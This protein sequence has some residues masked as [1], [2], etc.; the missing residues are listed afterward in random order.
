M[1]GFGFPAIVGGDFNELPASAAIA[2]PGVGMAPAFVDSSTACG[3]DPSPTYPAWWPTLKIDYW[4]VDTRGKV[5]AAST[6]VARC[7]WLSDH[8]P[9]RATFEIDQSESPT[10]RESE[11]LRH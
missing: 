11:S 4:F 2:Q 5:K 3:V 1:A 7:V 10:V 8:Y 6:S 9:L